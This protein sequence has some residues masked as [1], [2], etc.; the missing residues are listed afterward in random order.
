MLGVVSG[1]QALERCDPVLGGAHKC[2]QVLRQSALGLRNSCLHQCP[3]SQPDC[4]EASFRDRSPGLF[5]SMLE[6]LAQE[7]PYP[8]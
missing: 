4:W 6:V 5:I 8:Q 1:H 3:A 7:Y 2:Q